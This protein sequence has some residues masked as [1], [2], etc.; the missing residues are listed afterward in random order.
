MKQVKHWQDPISAA[1]RVFGSFTLGH[2]VLW[3]YGGHRQRR[4]HR[5]ALVATS[6]G[7]ILFP[8]AWEEWTEA[9]LRLWLIASL[10]A[11][12]FS[13]MSMPDARRLSP[14]P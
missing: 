9:V 8:C 7:A 14:A 13:T 6:L 4:D 1:W 3:R 5:L 12:G 11:L 2:R 10:W